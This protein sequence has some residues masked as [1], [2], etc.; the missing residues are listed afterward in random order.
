[1]TV[2]QWIV[3]LNP[4]QGTWKR[5][6]IGATGKADKGHNKHGNEKSAASVSDSGT[7]HLAPL[8]SLEQLF[9]P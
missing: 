6:S 7:T 8:W 9:L 2:L 4:N 3:G 5:L 1:M